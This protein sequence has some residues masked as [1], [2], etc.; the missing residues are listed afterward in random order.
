ML[1]PFVTAVG[2]FV[3]EEPDSVNEIASAVGLDRVQL[4]GSETVEC[5]AKI[6]L[7]V[8][9]VVRLAT[10]KDLSAIA[11]YGAVRGFLVDAKVRG[12]HGGTGRLAN[13]KLAR[14]ACERG[15]VILAGGLTPENVAETI[16]AVGP[17]GVDVASGVERESGKKDAARMR[18]FVEAVREAERG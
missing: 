6:E 16:R 9:K 15:P 7:P 14:V 18:A 13:W 8:I 5:C 3:D 11:A 10:R 4:A 12:R 2:V 1:P 17:A